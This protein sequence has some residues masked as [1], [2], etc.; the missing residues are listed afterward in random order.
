MPDRRNRSKD[1][2][3]A[4]NTFV[5]RVA[6]NRA[7]QYQHEDSAGEGCRRSGAARRRAPEG[8]V[9]TVLALEGDETFEADAETE[10]M[11]VE[12]MAQSGGGRTTLLKDLL[13][14]MRSRE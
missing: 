14:E 13:A 2:R 10:N 5:T 9:V 6:T 1:P 8:T 12:A 3:Q 11:L 7:L 4:T